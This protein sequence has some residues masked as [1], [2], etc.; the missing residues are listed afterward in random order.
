MKPKNKS[1]SHPKYR[2][3][4]DGLRAIAVLSVIAFHA[5]PS[6]IQGGFI[7]V[8]I[9]FVIS[10]YLISTIIFENLE[11]DTFSFYEFYARRIKRI[12]PA[13][14]LVLIFCFTIGWFTLLADEFEQ[15]GKHITAG[16]GFLSNFILWNEAGYFDNSSETKPLLHLWSLGIEEQFYIVWPF[17]L[18]FSWKRNFNLLIVTIIIFIVSLWLNLKGIKEDNIATFYSPITR[19]WELLA[20]SLLAWLNL[21]KDIEISRKKNKIANY[22][23][24]I[25]QKK[26]GVKSYLALT[27][28]FSVFGL[29]ILSCGLFGITKE[30]SFP[31]KWAIIPVIGTAFLIMAGSKAFINQ[32]ILSN[33]VLVWFGLISFPLYL[34]H[35][36]LLS[37]ARIFEHEAPSLNIRFVVVTLSIILAWLTYNFIERPIRNKYS[38]NLTVTFLLLLMAIIGFVGYNLYS[39]D[40]YKYRFINMLNSGVN[41]A[42]SY[43]WNQGFRYGECFIEASNEKTNKFSKICGQYNENNNSSLLI[44]GDSHSASLYPGLNSYAKSNNFSLYQYTASGCPPILDFYLNNRKE[45]INSNNSVYEEIKRLKPDSVILSAYWSMYDGSENWETLDTKK[46]SNTISKLKSLDINNII[47]VGHLPVYKINQADLLRKHTIWDKVNTKTYSKFKQSTYVYDNKIR[48]IASATGIDFISPLDILCDL[49][50][51]LL[52]VPGNEITPLSFDYGH[53]NHDGSIF[54]VSKFFESNLIKL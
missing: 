31:G 34:W 20:G 32:K 2:P 45:C 48:D 26:S 16:A 28:V 40:G 9:F 42:L 11:K 27:N 22:I 53:L 41:N 52:S 8:D 44:W 3:D 15:L 13:L 5:F 1:L 14:L 23:S 21:H 33:K 47:L 18:W 35:W 6:L 39:N 54:L 38:S 12:F 24:L 4:I 36:P 19:F 17:L 7:G 50:G 25:F 49:D 30:L 29:L 51:C 37:F 10:G 46:L 43:N